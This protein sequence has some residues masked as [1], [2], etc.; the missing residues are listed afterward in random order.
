MRK[1]SRMQQ[2]DNAWRELTETWMDINHMHRT[3]L[4]RQ[5]NQDGLY[6]SQHQLLMYISEHPGQSQKEIA[7]LNRISPATAAV[8][9]K[10]LEKGGYIQRM[11]DEKDNRCNRICLTE[12]GE[13]AVEFSIRFFC[14]IQERMFA[15]IEEP[16]RLQMLTSLRKI[17]DNLAQV[18]SES[19]V[20][21]EKK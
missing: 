6:R 12:K 20:R 15:G 11:E 7:Q 2:E 4:E 5:L 10:K 21:E 17:K 1:C 16:E 14:E 3:I 9:L 8:T 19:E 18:L 13:I